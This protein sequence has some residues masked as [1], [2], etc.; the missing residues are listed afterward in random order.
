[1]AASA[2]PGVVSNLFKTWTLIFTADADTALQFAHGMTSDPTGDTNWQ[3][4]T[5]P[6]FV[7]IVPILAGYETQAVVLGT[8]DATNINVTKTLTAAGSG[9]PGATYLVQAWFYIPGIAPVLVSAI[10]PQ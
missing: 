8:V 3:K 10:T 2:T 1:M 6:H 7:N 9:L 5:T 4:G